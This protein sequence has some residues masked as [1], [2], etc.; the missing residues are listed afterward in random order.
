MIV[1]RLRY[2]IRHHLAVTS[3]GLLCFEVFERFRFEIMRVY[4]HLHTQ[5]QEGLV[6]K[7]VGLYAVLLPEEQL[8]LL[9][10]ETTP[11]GAQ[12]VLQVRFGLL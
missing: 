2:Q 8:E 10:G 5:F 12:L 7:L 9:L 6:L 3:R 1:P 11:L 4:F